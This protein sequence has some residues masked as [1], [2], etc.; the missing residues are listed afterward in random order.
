MDVEQGFHKEMVR[1]YEAAKEFDYS[2]MRFRQ[3]VFADGGVKAAKKLLR[4][5]GISE[6]LTRLCLEGQLCISMEAL[7]IREP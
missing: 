6:G 1:I 3:M 7:V 4:G 5:D 2:A